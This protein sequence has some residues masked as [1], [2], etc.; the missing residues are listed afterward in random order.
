MLL[1]RNFWI[2]LMTSLLIINNIACSEK[3]KVTCSYGNLFKINFDYISIKNAEI[4]TRKVIKELNLP[5]E[6][7]ECLKELF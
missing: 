3:S 2:L 1:R 4:E 5:E 6:R 7:L